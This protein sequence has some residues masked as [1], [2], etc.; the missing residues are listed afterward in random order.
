VSFTVILDTGERRRH[1]SPVVVH[2]VVDETLSPRSPLGDSID[3]F[4]RREDSERFVEEIRGDEPELAA[5]LR[6]E[7]RELEAGGAN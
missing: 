2:A 1:R 5:F 4:V 7:E 6:I 3:V